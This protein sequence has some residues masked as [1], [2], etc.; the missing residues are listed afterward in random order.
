MCVQN[1]S[2]YERNTEELVKPKNK[3]ADQSSRVVHKS[4]VLNGTEAI[5][6]IL[7]FVMIN[8]WN[9]KTHIADIPRPNTL[10]PTPSPHEPNKMFIEVQMIKFREILRRFW[11]VHNE[12]ITNTGSWRI[13]SKLNIQTLSQQL[14][15]GRSHGPRKT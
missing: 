12:E 11:V 1:T 2:V 9:N 8:C 15:N 14:E 10:P 6:D 3:L 4:S 5:S 13:V 7:L